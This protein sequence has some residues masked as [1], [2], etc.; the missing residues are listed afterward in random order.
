[1]E[2]ALAEARPLSMRINLWEFRWPLNTFARDMDHAKLSA[3][4]QARLVEAEAMTLEEY[5]DALARRDA[6]RALYARPRRCVRRGDL[7]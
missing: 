5:Q 4:M 6:I 2:A 1:M 3:P 7:A